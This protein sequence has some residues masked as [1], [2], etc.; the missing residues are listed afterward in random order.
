MI[1]FYKLNYNLILY[2][3]SIMHILA[4]FTGF[5]P[6]SY[7]WSAIST[8]DIELLKSNRNRDRQNAVAFYRFLTVSDVM[9]KIKYI[10][11]VSL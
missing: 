7:L 3:T 4:I 9:F 6:N 5:I 8:S 11:H 1:Y 2:K 10:F